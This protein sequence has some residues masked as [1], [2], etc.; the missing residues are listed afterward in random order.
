MHGSAS[1]FLKVVCKSLHSCNLD[2]FGRRARMPLLEGLNLHD[3]SIVHVTQLFSLFSLQFKEDT[4]LVMVVL[5]NF[6]QRKF[7]RRAPLPG[8]N[9]LEHVGEIEDALLKSK[10]KLNAALA[11][12][13]IKARVLTIDHLLPDNVRKN[14][15]LGKQMHLCCWVNQFKAR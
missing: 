2:Y 5:C 14:Q 11:R 8:E 1:S 13:R 12:S 4:C 10:T 3:L 9:L 15:I 6:Q 7:Q